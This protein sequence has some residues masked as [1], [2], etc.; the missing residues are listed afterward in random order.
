MPV[1]KG[2]SGLFCE[3]HSQYAS[4]LEVNEPFDSQ[5]TFEVFPSPPTFVCISYRKHLIKKIL[6]KKTKNQ[7]NKQKKPHKPTK[8]FKFN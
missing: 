5:P 4:R 3:L 1:Q 6:L 7:K 2:V 8:T